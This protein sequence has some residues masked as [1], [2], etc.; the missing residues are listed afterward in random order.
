[1]HGSSAA[2]AARIVFDGSGDGRSRLQRG[3]FERAALPAHGLRIGLHRRQPRRHRMVLLTAPAR[4][5]RARLAP[6]V[7]EPFFCAPTAPVWSTLT[8]LGTPPTSHSSGGPRLG[9]RWATWDQKRRS[10]LRA[11][12]ASACQHWSILVA[13]ARFELA[14]FGL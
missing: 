10:P 14:T 9:H 11:G 4:Q 2:A 7:V 12:L 3:Q 1:M 13:G 6:P 5:P 8:G